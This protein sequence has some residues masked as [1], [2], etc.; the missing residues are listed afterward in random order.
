MN[1]DFE[2]TLSLE[3]FSRYL[4]WAAGDRDRALDLYALNTRLSEVLYT[5]LQV[6][7]V[8]LRNRVHV[9]L[10][11]ARHDRWFDDDGFLAGYEAG[12]GAFNNTRGS[13]RS[14]GLIHYPPAG[15][16]RE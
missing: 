16:A 8:T 7:Q 14:L 5:P 12:A 2:A 3:R 10:T 4:G 1:S 13:L 6:L 11:E 9:V 15:P